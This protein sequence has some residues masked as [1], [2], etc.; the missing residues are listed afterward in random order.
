MTHESTP[1]GEE[2][3]TLPHGA[4]M[5]CVPPWGELL[6]SL[7]RRAPGTTVAPTGAAS[8]LRPGGGL[9]ERARDAR[10]VTRRYRC[11]ACEA[12]WR[13]R[14]DTTIPERI[15]LALRLHGWS[16]A[17]AARAMGVN[18]GWFVAGSRRGFTPAILFR[19]ERATHIPRSLWVRGA[20]A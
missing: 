8:G 9:P 16:F 17:A 7:R 18:E 11:R 14:H 19:L 20:D 2:P 15:R 1:L 6:D 12:A 5:P 10:R 4:L 13:Q 3:V